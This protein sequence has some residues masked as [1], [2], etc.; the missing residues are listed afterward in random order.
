MAVGTMG[1]PRYFAAETAE[2]QSLAESKR[3]GSRDKAA[4]EW[5]LSFRG[6]RGTERQVA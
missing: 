1:K 6:K 4:G 3:A 5:I 2:E